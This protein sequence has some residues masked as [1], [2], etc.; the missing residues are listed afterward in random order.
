MSGCESNGV[1]QAV[2]V[3]SY[4]AGFKMTWQGKQDE[5]KMTWQDELCEKKKIS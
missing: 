3:P 2:L 4:Q 5:F 1:Y